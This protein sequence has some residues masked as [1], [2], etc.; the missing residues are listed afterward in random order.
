[1]SLRMPFSV[2][3]VPC[4][5]GY[6]GGAAVTADPRSGNALPLL[7]PRLPGHHAR[8]ALHLLSENE[9]RIF[10]RVRVVFP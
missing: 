8:R 5:R 7:K 4:S 10:V 3:M 9:E 2:V 1:M 6:D